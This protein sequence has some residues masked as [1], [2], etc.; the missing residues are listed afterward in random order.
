M[1]RQRDYLKKIANKTGSL[2]LRQAFQQIKN[3]VQYRI[4]KLRADYYS[5][6]MEQNKGNLRKTWKVLKQALNKDVKVTKINQINHE[7]NTISEEKTISNTFNNHFVS[8]GDKLARNIPSS[9]YM[10]TEYLSKAKNSS[11]RFEFKKIQATD[12]RKI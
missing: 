9:S 8:V 10:F 6:T 5:K 11:A 3:K 7:G 1:I 2:I 12:V 4:R